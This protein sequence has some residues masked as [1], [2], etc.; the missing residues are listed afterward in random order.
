MIIYQLAFNTTTL[1]I[2][3]NAQF[4]FRLCLQEDVR[5]A[6]AEMS[7]ISSRTMKALRGLLKPSKE[8]DEIK[9][10]TQE[11]DEELPSRTRFNFISTIYFHLLTGPLGSNV[12]ALG[13]VFAWV[14]T[15]ITKRVRI[16]ID[17]RRRWKRKVYA[18]SGNNK[19]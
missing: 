6:N 1:T 8:K 4:D 13:D 7:Q 14:A 15:T 12:R 18:G 3:Q 17:W 2:F 9:D 16:I 10:K 11:Y 19:P 5:E